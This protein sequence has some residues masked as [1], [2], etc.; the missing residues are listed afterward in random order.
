LPDSTS[1]AALFS[2]HKNTPGVILNF[3]RSV[4]TGGGGTHEIA[5]I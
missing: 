5:P 4:G 3:P 2:A 1:Y